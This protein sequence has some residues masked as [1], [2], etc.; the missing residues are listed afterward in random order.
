MS[1]ETAPLPSSDVATLLITPLALG[2]VILLANWVPACRFS[3]RRD[4]ILTTFSKPFPP[5][6]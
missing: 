5:L 1:V 6:E 2:A 3:K 4:P